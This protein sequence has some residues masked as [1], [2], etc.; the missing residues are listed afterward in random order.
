MEI[1]GEVACC[2]EV[3][4]KAAKNTQ[5]KVED[6]YKRVK[7]SSDDVDV[8]CLWKLKTSSDDAGSVIYERVKAAKNVQ[9]RAEDIYKRMRSK[10]QWR[11]WRYLLF[12]KEWRASSDDLGEKGVVRGELAKDVEYEAEDNHKRWTELK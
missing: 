3:S 4:G 5:Y 7:A 11:A 8:C 2:S 6:I 10:Q 9:Y 12:M 1:F